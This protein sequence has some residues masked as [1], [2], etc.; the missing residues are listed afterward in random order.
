MPTPRGQEAQLDQVVE[1]HRIAREGRIDNAS[2]KEEDDQDQF[3]SCPDVLGLDP[4]GEA[5]TGRAEALLLKDPD[6]DLKVDFRGVNPAA[7][8]SSFGW[9]FGVVSVIVVVAAGVPVVS[10]LPN[11]RTAAPASNA[12]TTA[13][14]MAIQ[15]NC[16]GLGVR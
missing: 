10:V 11:A 14:I 13:M 15:P 9:P 5:P 8:G 1:A 2:G 7:A 12:P 3:S 4:V 16:F 6:P